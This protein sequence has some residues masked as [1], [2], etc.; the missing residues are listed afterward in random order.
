MIFTLFPGGDATAYAYILKIVSG[1]YIRAYIF[2][3]TYVLYIV[4]ICKSVTH[5]T[6]SS[7]YIQY[8]RSEGKIDY[9]LYAYYYY[10][11]HSVRIHFI[12]LQ[13]DFHC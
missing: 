4:Y 1:G 10:Y 7:Y 9:I 3:S 5:K 11:Y 6:P 2:I 12:V 8:T 13:R